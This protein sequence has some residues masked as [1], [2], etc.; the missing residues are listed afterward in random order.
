MSSGRCLYRIRG[1]VEG[2]ELCRRCGKC[3]REKL[4]VCGVVFATPVMCDWYDK[5]TGL[6]RVY[7]RRH[8][9]NPYCL[10]RKTAI[11]K[12]VFPADCPYVQG[13]KGYAGPVEGVVDA[14]IL[15]M[16]DEGAI[17]SEEELR[18]EIVKRMRRLG[19]QIPAPLSMPSQCRR[20]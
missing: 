16:L 1:M 13:I 7:E 19:M 10:D 4:M 6:C 14:G 11:A 8:Q 18:R 3:C 5:A 15:L 9:V 20:D 2:E 12:G 17:S